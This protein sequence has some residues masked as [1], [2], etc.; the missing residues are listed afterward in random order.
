MCKCSQSVSEGSERSETNLLRLLFLH[1]N[2]GAA[3]NETWKTNIPD[4]RIAYRKETLDNEFASLLLYLGSSGKIL[5][6][7][8]H[9]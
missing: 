9:G 2:E 7:E 3:G 1:R 5:L 6:Q 4:I 8:S